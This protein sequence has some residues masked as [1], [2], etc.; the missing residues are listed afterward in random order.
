MPRILC[1]DTETEELTIEWHGYT[2]ENCATFAR[3]WPTQIYFYEE[4]VDYR[5]LLKSYIRGV[6]T[7]A[8][9][10]EIKQ[11]RAEIGLEHMSEVGHH[12]AAD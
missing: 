2:E 10:Q 3:Q 11:L 7:P 1:Y 8:Q 5:E 6:L 12:G 9:V 4:E